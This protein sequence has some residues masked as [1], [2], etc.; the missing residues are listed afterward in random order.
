[1]LRRGSVPLSMCSDYDEIP[2]IVRTLENR[3][4]IAL[5][6]KEAEK[7]ALKGWE[8]LSCNNAKDR[9]EKIKE[10]LRKY[11]MPLSGVLKN[12]KGVKHDVV[13]VGYEDDYI[14][15]HNHTGSDELEKRK[16]DE[17]SKA[18]YLD[19]G[20][21]MSKLPFADVKETDWHYKYIK[22]LYDEKIIKG[23][24]SNK[25]APNE[26]LTR[27]EATALL[28]RALYGME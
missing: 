26:N 27:A 17:F 25:F 15:F 19:G 16:Y 13:I 11:N 14:Y 21:D 10:Y 22:K 24:D 12:Y 9:F 7:Y 4:D 23:V 20:I 5:L 3:V 8:D 18:Y 28:C 6:D 1:M 2:D